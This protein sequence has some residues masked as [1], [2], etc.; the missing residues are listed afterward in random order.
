MLETAV[1][2]ATGSGPVLLPDESAATLI[3]SLPEEFRNSCG[4][5][6]L[7][8][9]ENE[10]GTAKWTVRV[11]Y[12]LRR[13]EGTEAVLAI[14]CASALTSYYDERPA[15]VSLTPNLATLDLIPLAEKCDNCS[16]LYHLEF[17]QA[18]PALGAQLVELQVNH[19]TENPCCGGG[20]EQSGDR[21]MILDLSRGRQVLA[22][23]KRTE[24]DSN[25]DSNDG[26]ETIC[27]AKI[28]Y[29]HDATR[30]L[31]TIATVTRCM[32]NKK[33]L[34]EVKKRTFRWNAGAH[35]FDEVK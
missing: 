4:A 10:E 26:T 6:W 28:S 30:N 17:S 34:P 29:L 24:V 31:Q 15:T 25:V 13:H 3:G 35:Q 8:F 9:G 1:S 19:S 22:V 27:E 11:L 12:S 2:G 23:D 16:D 18:F 20:D 21:M 5:M 33:P 32:E 7:G 14:S